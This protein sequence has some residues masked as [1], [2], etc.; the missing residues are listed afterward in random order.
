MIVVTIDD[1]YD[2]NKASYITFGIHDS[3]LSSILSEYFVFGINLLINEYA[4]TSH[5]IEWSFHNNYRNYKCDTL[6]FDFDHY[7]DSLLLIT[8]SY[9]IPNIISSQKI[10]KHSA[11]Y[12][13]NIINVFNLFVMKYGNI[14]DQKIKNYIDGAEQHQEFGC[15]YEDDHIIVGWMGP[16]LKINIIDHYKFKII[17]EMMKLLI[18]EKIDND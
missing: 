2:N 8:T 1:M 3:I 14:N 9:D 16:F 18:N 15:Y 10:W 12:Q 5:T 17:I 6:G 4:I 11:N 13:F 7:T